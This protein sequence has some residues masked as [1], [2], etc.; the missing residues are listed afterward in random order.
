MPQQNKKQKKWT[1]EQWQEFEQQE[2]AAPKKLTWAEWQAS[3]AGASSGTKP[4]AEKPDDQAAEKP[5]AVRTASASGTAEKPAE[6][7][8]ESVQ[9]DL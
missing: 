3:K 9:Q 1:L 5:T 2:A 7:A 8:P 6:Q 4:T